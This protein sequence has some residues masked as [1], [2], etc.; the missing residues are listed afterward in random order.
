MCVS[1]TIHPLNK[2]KNFSGVMQYPSRTYPIMTT[3]EEMICPVCSVPERVPSLDC[4]NVAFQEGNYVV[5]RMRVF[6]V[7]VV[8]EKL[9]AKRQVEQMSF[10]R[11]ASHKLATLFHVFHEPSLGGVYASQP[12]VMEHGPLPVL[13]DV[14]LELLLHDFITPAQTNH[15]T[16]STRVKHISNQ[17]KYYLIFNLN[18]VN[19][20]TIVRFQ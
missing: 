16:V 12:R 4:V 13:V 10:I 8:H 18:L 15:P 14:N 11:I 9:R 5:E 1:V 7:D 19:T 17:V 20:A 3:G 2:I 6:N